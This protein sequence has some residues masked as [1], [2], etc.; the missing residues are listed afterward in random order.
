MVLAQRKEINVFDNNHLA[1]CLLELG[2]IKVRVSIALATRSGV[3]S[4]PS[5]TT[6]SPNSD[7]MD[8]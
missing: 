5:R 2:G 6:S 1:I 4:R 3:F 8:S 7:K